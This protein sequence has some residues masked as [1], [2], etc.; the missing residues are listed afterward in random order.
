MK[1][2]ADNSN[3][4]EIF[5]V[6]LCNFFISNIDGNVLFTRLFLPK[7]KVHQEFYIYFFLVKKVTP[8]Y[9]GLESTSI[10]SYFNVKKYI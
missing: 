8:V 7:K 2:S 5:N 9:S 3:E 6:V 10:V 4:D 1:W